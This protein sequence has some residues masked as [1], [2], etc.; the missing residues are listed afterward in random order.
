M[1]DWEKV[2]QMF[3]LKYICLKNVLRKS[4][5]SDYHFSQKSIIS[6]INYPPCPL[7][8]TYT[9]SLFKPMSPLRRQDGVDLVIG[10]CKERHFVMG[11]SDCPL[12]IHVHLKSPMLSCRLHSL[13]IYYAC[14]GR[15][16]RRELVPNSAQ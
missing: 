15:S 9:A 4:T 8:K 7:T 16:P 2:C 14:K 3:G 1:G 6:N 5:Y 12:Y 13:S 11:D 10:D